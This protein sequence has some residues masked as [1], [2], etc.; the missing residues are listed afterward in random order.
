M[1]LNIK[2]GSEDPRVAILSNLAHTPFGYGQNHY[3]SIE[4]AVQGIKFED[5]EI[6]EEIFNLHGKEA[7]K[8]GRGITEN[9]TSK[10]SF[11]WIHGIEKVG[12]N[13]MEHRRF[14]LNCLRCKFHQNELAKVCL[15]ATKNCELI[16][17]VGKEHVNTSL[18]A[19]VFIRMLGA[20]REECFNPM[21]GIEINFF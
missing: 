6:Q 17:D 4:G 11:V 1:I 5:D 8:K 21:K 16:H 19:D 15:M 13:S 3:E 9:L 2:S 14:I 20:V 7:L 18:P 12:Y 10:N